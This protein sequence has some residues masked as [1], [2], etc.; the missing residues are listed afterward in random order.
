MVVP[1]IVVVC[2]TDCA[3]QPGRRRLHAARRLVRRGSERFSSSPDAQ[4][5]A[6]IRPK[7]M[8]I[9]P[10][11]KRASFLREHS[12]GILQRASASSDPMIIIIKHEDDALEVSSNTLPLERCWWWWWCCCCLFLC[13]WTT[14]R[15]STMPVAAAAVAVAA[16]AVDDEDVC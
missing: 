13:Q 3:F 2:S 4:N 12:G 16:A 6:M 7:F 9:P 5:L 10:V 8:G 1:S 15:R 14:V 11:N